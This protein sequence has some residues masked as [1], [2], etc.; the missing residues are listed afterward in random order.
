MTAIEDIQA[1]KYVSKDM[2]IISFQ[3]RNDIITTL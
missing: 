1:T 3:K 2:N